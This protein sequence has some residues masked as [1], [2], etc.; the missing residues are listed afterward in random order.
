MGLF[1]KKK[2]LPL[3]KKKNLVELQ[4]KE[5]KILQVALVEKC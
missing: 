4:K 5:N 3:T 2:D 1:K